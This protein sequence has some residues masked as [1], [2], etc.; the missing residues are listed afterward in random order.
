VV[1]ARF[2]I[3]GA[4]ASVVILLN[5]AASAWTPTEGGSTVSQGIGLYQESRAGM[6][7]LGFGFGPWWGPYDSY[8]PPA[9]AYPPPVY[10]VPPPPPSRVPASQSRLGACQQFDSTVIVDGQQRIARGLAC[11]QPDGSWRIVR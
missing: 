10:S 11:P 3:A 5:A 6:V 2:P 7:G 1:T 4:F 8:A 9:Y